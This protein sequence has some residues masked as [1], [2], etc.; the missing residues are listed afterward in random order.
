MY[1]DVLRLIKEKVRLKEYVLTLHAEDE[2]ID[3]GLTHFDVENAVLTGK[4]VARQKDRNTNEWKYVIEGKTHG[5][6]IPMVVSKFSF[7]KKL[8]IITV[9]VK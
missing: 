6:E 7:S 5:S 2:I 9:Y 3:D 1:E 8:V 4:I